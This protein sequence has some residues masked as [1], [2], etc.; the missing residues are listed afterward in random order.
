MTVAAGTEERVRGIEQSVC[1]TVIV[2]R[3]TASGWWRSNAA[4]KPPAAD[5]RIHRESSDAFWITRP[6]KGCPSD[7]QHPVRLG[8][9]AR[10]R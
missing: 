1:Y 9:V 2:T 8:A 5:L 3:T 10:V 6:G 4:H 7:V